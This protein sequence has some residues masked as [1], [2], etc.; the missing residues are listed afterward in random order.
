MGRR[1]DGSD[2]APVLPVSRTPPA[3]P[4]ARRSRA[5][6][7][8]WHGTVGLDERDG[9]EISPSRWGVCRPS[10]KFAMLTPFRPMRSQHDRSHRH[11]LFFRRQV[12][13]A[14][15]RSKFRPPGSRGFPARRHE[16][17]RPVSVQAD[18]SVWLTASRAVPRRSGRARKQFMAFTTFTFSQGG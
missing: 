8:A 15:P 10:E 1:A 14:A 5:V 6:P 3:S 17:V 2:R 9:R 12:P 13:L 18:E 4:A 11:V 16:I 7:P